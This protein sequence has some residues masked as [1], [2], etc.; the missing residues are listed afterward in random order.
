MIYAL[1]NK[2]VGAK[3][4]TLVPFN[5]D[6]APEGHFFIHPKARSP[7]HIIVDGKKLH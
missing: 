3:N 2:A 6:T 1:H 4:I 5:T 7:H